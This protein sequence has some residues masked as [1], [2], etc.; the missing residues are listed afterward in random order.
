MQ[1][2][3]FTVIVCCVCVAAAAAQGTGFGTSTPDPSAAVEIKSDT[4]GLLIPRMTSKQRVN[5]T[6]PA[7]GL[8]VF[9]I[10]TNSFWY[11]ESTKWVELAD[12][13]SFS[14]LKSV[15]GSSTFTPYTIN[16]QRYMW[17]LNASFATGNSIA[18]PDAIISEY[19]GDED[20]CRVTISMTNW[21]GVTKQ[22][23]SASAHVSY[24]P[25]AG[26]KKEWRSNLGGSG[27][28]SVFNSGVDGV[29]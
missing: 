28:S 11:R 4:S 1:R 8:M 21:D 2:L 7:V 9:D 10:S 23:A 17:E 18:L 15:N 14:G 3:I 29:V 25:T 19:C 27:T 26:G 16:P 6:N 24:L 5:I 13:S 20:G 12:M 22:I